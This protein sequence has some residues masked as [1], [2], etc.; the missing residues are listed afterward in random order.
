MALVST[1][2]KIF[3]AIRNTV[4][5]AKLPVRPLGLGPAAH[6]E[7]QCYL[8]TPLYYSALVG[9]KGDAPELLQFC[10]GCVAADGNEKFGQDTAWAVVQDRA[11]L[12]GRAFTL[13][14]K[15]PEFGSSE[16]Q[17]EAAFSPGGLY[18]QGVAASQD[19]LCRILMDRGNANRLEIYRPT[20]LVIHDALEHFLIKL[21]ISAAQDSYIAEFEHA[22]A[23]VL[24][25]PGDLRDMPFENVVNGLKAGLER[26]ALRE[27]GA[28]P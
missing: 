27:R 1:A 9:R 22:L 11:Q 13:A 26:F 21:C 17:V 16:M 23:G 5:S 20:S 14:D 18:K 7:I 8:L 2:A 4:E 24:S 3:A 12:Y 19:L 15:Y 28:Q 25:Q 10:A 6:F